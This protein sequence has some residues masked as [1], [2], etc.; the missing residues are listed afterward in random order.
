MALYRVKAAWNGFSGAP[1]YS[2]FHFD[3][4]V[5]AN[6]LGAQNAAAAVDLFYDGL[7]MYLPTGVSVGVESAVEVID[8]PTGQLLDVLS[9][10]ALAANV[11][12]ATGNYSSAAGA[13]IT[14]NTVGVKNGRRVRG[15]TFIVP[16]SA[17]G[18][19]ENNGTLANGFITHLV[20]KGQAL[21]DGD[22]D[23]HVYSRPS[24]TGASDGSSHTVAGVRVADKTAILKS[25]RD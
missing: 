7:T 6:A 4:A 9:T 22:S 23:F 16:L 25:R 11:G 12:N 3:A 2:I 20:G 8:T 19:F 5:E 24:S 1:G 17:A 15:R 18:C 14:W 10:P 21:I 13:C